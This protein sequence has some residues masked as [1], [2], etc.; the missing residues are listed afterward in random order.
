MVQKNRKSVADGLGSEQVGL[1]V[2]VYIGR[3][4]V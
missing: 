1:A 4:D 3:E 2:M